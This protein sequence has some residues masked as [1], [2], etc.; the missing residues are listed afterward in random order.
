M[1]SA[2]FGRA[3]AEERGRVA[4][5]IHDGLAQY[6]FAISTQTTML[7]GGAPVEQVLPR[8]QEAAAA[9]QQ[10]ARF[11]VLTLSSAG[12]TAPF[13]A[14]L[15]RYV[16]FLTADGNWTSTSRSSAES[17]SAPTSRSRSSGSSRKVSP[18]SAAM[19]KRGARRC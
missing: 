16:G 14:A 9:A 7:A 19:R 1:R 6:L 11:A 10:E 8:L 12:G 2:E 17:S 13:D 15:N 4:R 18:T 5:D 3:V